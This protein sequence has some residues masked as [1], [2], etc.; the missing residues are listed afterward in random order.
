[1]I[2]GMA[3]VSPLKGIASVNKGM[4]KCPSLEAGYNVSHICTMSGSAYVH[5]YICSPLLAEASHS[6]SCTAFERFTDGGKVD[7]TQQ[8]LTF[9]AMH[10]ACLGFAL[11]K[12]RMHSLLFAV[13]AQLHVRFSVKAWACFQQPCQIG[14]L[15][16]LWAG[17]VIH[18]YFSHYFV[19]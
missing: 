9:V 15:L 3:M 8:K 7:V 1:M 16:R 11:Y 2:T 5:L 19:Q 10:L 4:C 18:I 13:V 17:Y 14:Q 12:V 6:M